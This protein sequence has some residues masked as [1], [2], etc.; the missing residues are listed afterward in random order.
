MTTVCFY[1]ITK[2]ST[3]TICDDSIVSYPEQCPFWDIIDY[4]IDANFKITT[5]DICIADDWTETATNLPLSI[6]TWN[7]S[8]AEME[9]YY[10]MN[11]ETWNLYTVDTNGNAYYY[12]SD[13]VKYTYQYYDVSNDEW[14]WAVSDYVGD[15]NYKIFCKQSYKNEDIAQCQEWQFYDY[16]V[17]QFKVNSNIAMQS[18]ECPIH[19]EHVCV[20]DSSKLTL[21]VLMFTLIHLLI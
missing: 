20:Y 11:D 1:R 6:C 7:I 16:E 12:N 14:L 10:F 9:N 21:S 13:D 4:G 17:S 2:I 8:S 5:G 3:C 15:S 19:A 18:S